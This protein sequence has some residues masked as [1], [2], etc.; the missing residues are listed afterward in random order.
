[1]EP[2]AIPSWKLA[3]MKQ[4]QAKKEASKQEPKDEDKYAGLPAWK[5]DLLIKKDEEARK[6]ATEKEKPRAGFAVAPVLRKR[7]DPALEVTPPA[8]APAAATPARA[9]PVVDVG[10]SV[11]ARLSSFG[12]TNTAAANTPLPAATPLKRTVGGAGPNPANG[13][14]NGAANGSAMIHFPPPEEAR[15]APV[16]SVAELVKADAP[17]PSLKERLSLFTR[18]ASGEALKESAD[19]PEQLP[20]AGAMA[21]AVLSTAPRLR[22]RIGMLVSKAPDT[23]APAQAPAGPT[24]SREREHTAAST[25]PALSSVAAAV[26]APAPSA[27]SL[28]VPVNEAGE[29]RL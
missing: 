8:P 9:A 17:I 14:I 20:A 1:M 23:T 7:S 22:E 28:S 29:V 16:P 18:S 25:A 19:K 13:S 5:R 2:G 11:R 15:P 26:A 6:A 3:L 12:V 4:K 27:P 10:V 24:L 21:A